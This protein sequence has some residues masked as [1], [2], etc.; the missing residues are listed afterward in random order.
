[1]L[2]SINNLLYKRVIENE[3]D[4]KYSYIERSLIS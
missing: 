3:E 4:K 2:V 1:M